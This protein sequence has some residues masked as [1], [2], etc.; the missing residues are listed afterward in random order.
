[1]IVP[2]VIYFIDDNSIQGDFN[3]R[4]GIITPPYGGVM[5]NGIN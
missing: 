2:T 4:N 3:N 1:M 5:A